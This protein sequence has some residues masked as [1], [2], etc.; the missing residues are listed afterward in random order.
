MARVIAKGR[1][2]RVVER[3]DSDRGQHLILEKSHGCDAMG[4]EVWLPAREV[5]DLS[6]LELIDTMVSRPSLAVVS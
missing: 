4:V 6:V 5:T 2:L 3:H 1:W